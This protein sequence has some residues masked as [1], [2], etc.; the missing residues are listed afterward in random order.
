MAPV[1]FIILSFLCAEPDASIE[2]LGSAVPEK[3]GVWRNPINQLLNAIDTYWESVYDHLSG[4]R[5]DDGLRLCFKDT[6]TKIG[7][8]TL[9]SKEDYLHGCEWNLLRKLAGE[10]LRDARLVSVDFPCPLPFEEWVEV[11]IDHSSYEEYLEYM[12]RHCPHDY[13]KPF[14]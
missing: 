6:L 3:R 1:S 10:I 4:S 5:G 12:R 7:T 8:N 11:R 14:E 9:D 2:C 13:V